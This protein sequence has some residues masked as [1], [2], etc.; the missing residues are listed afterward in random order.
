MGANLVRRVSAAGHRCVVSDVDPDAV[1]ALETKGATG[2][3]SLGDLAAVSSPRG[4][5][6]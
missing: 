4:S 2:A 5:W 1:E 3:S 6:T